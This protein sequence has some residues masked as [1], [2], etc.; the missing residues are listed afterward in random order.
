VEGGCE[1]DWDESG[2]WNSDECLDLGCC[3]GVLSVWDVWCT[4]AVLCVILAQLAYRTSWLCSSTGS[5]LKDL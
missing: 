5:C 2:D 1:G 4:M 3:R